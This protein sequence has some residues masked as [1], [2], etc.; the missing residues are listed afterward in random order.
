VTPVPNELVSKSILEVSSDKE[1]AMD[2][3]PSKANMN[4]MCMGR[5][6]E[7]SFEED[8]DDRDIKQLV[9]SREFGSVESERESS[10]HMLEEWLE[11]EAERLRPIHISLSESSAA[12][13]VRA[14]VPGVKKEDLRIKVQPNRV[15]ITRRPAIPKRSGAGFSVSRPNETSRVI[16][17]Q[18]PVTVNKVRIAVKDG[19]LELELAKAEPAKQD[20][21]ESKT[22]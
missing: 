8:T 12:L 4:E 10:S 1:I 20:R 17:L 13:T 2:E 15:M 14:D 7:E 16:E 18:S 22:V 11:H 9:V 3:S 21:I 5:P 6:S 19:V